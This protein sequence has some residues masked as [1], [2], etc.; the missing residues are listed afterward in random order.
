MGCS[1]A[2]ARRDDDDGDGAAQHNTNRPN[3]RFARRLRESCRCTGYVNIVKAI[4]HAAG[5]IR[6]A[7]S[8][9][10]AQGVA[11]VGEAATTA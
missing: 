3:Q 10:P 4:Q 1:A 7:N 9:T 5:A 6:A 11:A 8:A 2:F